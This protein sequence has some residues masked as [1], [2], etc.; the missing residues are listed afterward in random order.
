MA[1]ARAAGVTCRRQDRIASVAQQLSV[2]SDV[3]GNQRDPR[4]QRLERDERKAFPSRRD[5]HR[6]RRP[7]EASRLGLG[8][9]QTNS[10]LNAELRDEPIQRFSQRA[11]ADQQERHPGTAATARTRR[12]VI[13]LRCQAAGG[14]DQRDVGGDAESVGELSPRGGYRGR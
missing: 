13:L 1:H 10:R 9:H 11:V 7:D 5:H 14:D 4:R 3:A 12:R 8:S 2:P 6:V